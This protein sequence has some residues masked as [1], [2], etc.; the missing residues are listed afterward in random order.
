MTTESVP[1]HR[2]TSAD[3]PA[4]HTEG[5]RSQAHRVGLGGRAAWPLQP[6]GASLSR[7]LTLNWLSSQSVRAVSQADV[8]ADRSPDQTA[9]ACRRFLETGGQTDRIAAATA[10]ATAS[11][12]TSPWFEIVWSAN[13]L[14]TAP[15]LKS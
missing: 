8:L 9:Q 6:R 1:L 11:L 13:R 4:E 2:L 5:L 10:Q 3:S 14:W 12:S 15:A 7:S